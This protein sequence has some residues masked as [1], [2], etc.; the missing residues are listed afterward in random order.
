MSSNIRIP[1][2]FPKSSR[3]L[4]TVLVDLFFY[5]KYCMISVKSKLNK[6]EFISEDV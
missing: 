6:V 2:F 1:I 5:I 4:S 3:F